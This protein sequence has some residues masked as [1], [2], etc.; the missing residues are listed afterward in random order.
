MELSYFPTFATFQYRALSD[1]NAVVLEILMV[2][3]LLSLMPGN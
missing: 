1:A 3:V 2:A